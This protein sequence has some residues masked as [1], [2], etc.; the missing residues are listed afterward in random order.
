MLMQFIRQINAS[1]RKERTEMIKKEN[2][3]TDVDYNALCMLETH[4]MHEIRKLGEI[5]VVEKYRDVENWA[6]NDYEYNF[7]CGFIR[8]FSHRNNIKVDV[9][10]KNLNKIVLDIIGFSMFESGRLTDAKLKYLRDSSIPEFR[11][12]GIY[13]RELSEL[14]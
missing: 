5:G 14:Y 4:L 11:E 6:S 1:Y 3:A 13:L 9:K 10:T 7:L 12:A 8:H 2:I